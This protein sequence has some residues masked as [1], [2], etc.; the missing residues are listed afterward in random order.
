[1]KRTNFFIP[2]QTLAALKAESLKTGINVSELVRR[3]LDAYLK[4]VTK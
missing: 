3:A 2:E 4:E 1:M